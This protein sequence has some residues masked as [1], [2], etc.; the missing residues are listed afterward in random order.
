MENIFTHEIFTD[1]IL[2]WLLIFTLVFAVLEKS[3]LLGEGKRQINAIVSLVVATI[4]LAF[5]GSRDIIVNLIPIFVIT[6]VVLFIF[7]LLYAFVSGEKKGDPLNKGVKIAIGI[8][9]AI[10]VAVSVLVVTGTWDSFWSWLSD[11]NM[12]ANIIFIVIAVGAVVA[13][14]MNKGEKESKDDE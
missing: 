5:P 3:K 14:L 7:L 10:V 1:F 9:I 4:L 8:G 6:L 12:G 2:P 11:S 13:V